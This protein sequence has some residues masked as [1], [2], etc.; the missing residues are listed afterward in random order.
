MFVIE[1]HGDGPTEA[2]TAPKLLIVHTAT[3]T[4][5]I[6]TRVMKCILGVT[7]AEVAAEDVIESPAGRGGVGGEGPF[8]FPN[9][10]K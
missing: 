9:V 8:K 7:V 2:P 6:S 3:M 10:G 4:T 5:T 1:L